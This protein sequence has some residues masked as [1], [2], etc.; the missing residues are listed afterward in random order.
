MLTWMVD[1]R[2]RKLTTW[3]VFD[4]ESESEVQNAE[5][6]HP[7]PK[8]EGKRSL[9][10]VFIRYLLYLAFLLVHGV[11]WATERAQEYRTR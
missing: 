2:P 11:T 8:F 10:F 4:V 1:V 9:Q 5:F 3:V 6:L 7:N